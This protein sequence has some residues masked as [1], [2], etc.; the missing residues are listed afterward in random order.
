MERLIVLADDDPDLRSVYAEALRRAGYEVAEASDGQEAVA[1][2]HDRKPRLLLLDVWMP[3]V[4]GFEVLDLLR[5]A[6]DAATMKVVML[7]NL[8]DAESRLESF[9]GGVRDYWVKGIALEE[10]LDRVRLALAED[11]LEEGAAAEPF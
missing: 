8:D 3:S 6:P 4:N 2:V 10:F 9:S 1:L 5:H 11:G 7:S